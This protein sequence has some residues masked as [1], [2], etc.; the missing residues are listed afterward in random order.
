MSAPIPSAADSSEG[1]RELR[2]KARRRNPPR[3]S[4]AASKAG[5][6]TTR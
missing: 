4:R 1:S 6:P 3:G 5:R 2:R